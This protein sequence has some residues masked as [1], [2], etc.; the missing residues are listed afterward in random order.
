VAGQQKNSVMKYD[1]LTQRN[2]YLFVEKMPDYRGGEIAFMIDFVKHFQHSYNRCN[3]ESIQTKLH[4]Q[5]VIDTSGHL[6]GGRIYNKR[7]EVL[8]TFEKAGLKALS[9]MQDWQVG[10]HNG[11]PV[12]VLMT[13][14]IHIDLK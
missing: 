4:V 5:F 1:S 6:I 7:N 10:K 3:D 11:K 9:L 2:V 12:D 13:R 14:M 8:T